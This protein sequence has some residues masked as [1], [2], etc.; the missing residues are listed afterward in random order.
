MKLATSRFSRLLSLDNDLAAE[1]SCE[2]APPTSEA[3]RWT[4]EISV[5]TCDVPSAARCTLVE[6]SCVAAPCCST[7][8]AIADEIS[9]IRAMVV[10]ISLMAE[11]ESCVAD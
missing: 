1:S 10:P 7:A 3:P 8:V 4:A 6:I 9:E 11:T 5:S 2:D